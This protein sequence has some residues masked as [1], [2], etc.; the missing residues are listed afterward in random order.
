MNKKNKNLTHQPKKKIT[1]KSKIVWGLDSR[2]KR[3]ILVVLIGVLIVVGVQVTNNFLYLF[4]KIRF[5]N[6]AKT[7]ETIH[8]R[9]RVAD[10]GVQWE[11]EK[12]CARHSAKFR[13]GGAYCIMSTRA[14]IVLQNEPQA[15]NMISKYN[16]ILEEFNDL[17][18]TE[19]GYSPQSY[20][21]KFPKGLEPGAGGAGFRDR[22]T[23]MACA[24]VYEIPE[25]SSRYVQKDPSQI[26]LKMS[27]SCNAGARHTH[28]GAFKQT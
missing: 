6:A 2:P 10:P 24:I 11:Y 13:E 22:K 23:N 27:F 26:L 14:D 4:D 25:E 3:Y 1:T 7:V 5:D 9:F 8:N 17:L 18:I 16:I 28:Y 12:G 21:P 20:S 15:Q 19:N